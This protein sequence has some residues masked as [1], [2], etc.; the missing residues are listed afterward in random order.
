MKSLT[1]RLLTTTALIG[2]VQAVSRTSPPSG[3]LHVAKSG[4]TYTTVQA[5]IDSLSTTSTAAQCVFINQ[6]TYTEQVYIPDRAAQL[7]IY[8]YTTDDTSY[9]ANGATLTFNKDAASAGNNDA[10]GTLRVHAENVKVYNLDV[11]N[12]CKCWV[13]TDWE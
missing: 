3:C 12:S 8:G 2:A 7:T 9:A 5:A 13:N 11:V 10:S 4:G 6:G 1:M